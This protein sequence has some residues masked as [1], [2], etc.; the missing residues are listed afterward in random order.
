M[1][2]NSV[3][4]RHRDI[5]EKLLPAD[6]DEILKKYGHL[7]ANSTIPHCP[8]SSQ[9]HSFAPLP[10]QFQNPY[11]M[12]DIPT[13]ALSPFRFPCHS[14]SKRTLFRKNEIML[15]QKLRKFQKPT[16]HHPLIHR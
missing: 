8:N 15:F 14:H 1:S 3:G 4:K 16:L 6:I 10:T 5:K 9:L 13:P 7:L 11:Y 2:G 12:P